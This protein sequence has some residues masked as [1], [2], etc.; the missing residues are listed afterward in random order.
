MIYLPGSYQQGFAPRDFEPRFSELWRGCVVALSP[1][2]GPT[3]TVLRDW[4]GVQNHATL[5]NV[6]TNTVW[7]ASEG[8]TALSFDGT[9]DYGVNN[10][11]NLPQFTLS[12]WVFVTTDVSH[13]FVAKRNAT[14][15]SWE[16]GRSAA[17]DQLLV[18]INANTNVA[19]GGLINLNTW[20]HVAG[21][22]DGST[23]RAYVNG[24]LVN[25]A[26]YT[27]PVAVNAVQT[28]YGARALFAG[29]EAFFPLSMD[30][31]MIHNRP[32][33]NAEIRLLAFRRGIAYEPRIPTSLGASDQF[34]T[35]WLSK[36][37]SLI[38]G[39]LA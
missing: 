18:R 32:L 29:A 36:Q 7:T 8:R 17:N 16:M 13:V 15:Y 14:D 1:C 20:T 26:A 3:G 30:S 12:A 23:I 34:L 37:S 27:T 10:S 31:I 28:T 11:I 9:D 6:T 5:T 24:A 2:L 21:S 38:G 39:G 33:H 19:T 25:E 22:F 4:S 35:A